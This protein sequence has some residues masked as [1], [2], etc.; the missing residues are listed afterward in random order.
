MEKEL[1]RLFSI[2][3]LITKYKLNFK[4][5]LNYINK[6]LKLIENGTNKNFRSVD[7][8]LLKKKNIF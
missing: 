4:T 5:E 2:P 3:V 6:K 1:I 7:S 8:Y